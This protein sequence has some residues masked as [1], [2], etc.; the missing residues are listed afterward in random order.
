M[1]IIGTF[2]TEDLFSGKF[3]VVDDVRLVPAGTAAFTRGAVLTDANI[4][5]LAGTV[6]NADCIA[7]EDAD[8]SAA[9]EPVRCVVAIAGGF[10][11]NAL[12]AGDDT[13]PATLKAALRAKS[14]YL[15]AAL[16]VS[17]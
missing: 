12:S 3:P 15:T 10:N 11:S 17:A 14:I 5:V 4:P 16:T 9:T 6:A 1:G 8:A 2:T 7:L 13:D